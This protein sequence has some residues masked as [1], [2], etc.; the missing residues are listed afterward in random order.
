MKTRVPT[1]CLIQDS[2]R[3]RGSAIFSWG[4]VTISAR[5]Q[6]LSG[7]IGGHNLQTREPKTDSLPTIDEWIVTEEFQLNIVC[8]YWSY[9]NQK[10][11]LTVTAVHHR[12][13]SH[14]GL[15]LYNNPVIQMRQWCLLFHLQ[16]QW[17]ELRA[18]SLFSTCPWSCWYHGAIR[19]TLEYHIAPIFAWNSKIIPHLIKIA[20]IYESYLTIS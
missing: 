15:I 12:C 14:N 3:I 9:I 7:P 17:W 1:K 4:C 5:K 2:G 16:N 6:E 13:H 8:F 10:L 11:E 19:W 20:I 18:G